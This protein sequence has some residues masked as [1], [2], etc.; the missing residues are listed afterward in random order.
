L[1]EVAMRDTL[2]R[3]TEVKQET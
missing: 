1:S 3:A 2:S